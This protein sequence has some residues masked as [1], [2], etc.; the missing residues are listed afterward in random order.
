MP[1]MIYNLYLKHIFIHRPI[2]N[3]RD[4]VT[5]FILCINAYVFE[6]WNCSI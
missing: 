2:L 5:E 4:A 3:I 1:N 6:L